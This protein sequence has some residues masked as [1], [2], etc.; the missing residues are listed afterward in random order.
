MF[1]NLIFRLNLK[2]VWSRKLKLFIWPLPM[3]VW[4]HSS[5]DDYK[6]FKTKI[7]WPP[8]S[9][10]IIRGHPR[11]SKAI[12]GQPRPTE[13]NWGHQRSEAKIMK[14][15]LTWKPF[16]H[17]WKLKRKNRAKTFEIFDKKVEFYTTWPLTIGLHNRSCG[18]RI[19]MTNF[20]E[21]KGDK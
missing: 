8:R 3:A 4:G 1:Q 2:I 13:A 11:S 5:L 7:R 15:H 20:W 12:R 9:F 16:C 14:L 6:N 21:L 10:E 17:F 18:P 19:S